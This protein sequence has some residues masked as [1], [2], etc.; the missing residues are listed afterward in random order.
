M[1]SRTLENR[2]HTEGTSFQQLLTEVRQ[3]KAVDFL[4]SSDM[5]ID[6][7]GR[8]VGFSEPTNFTRAFKDWTGV[9]P[10]HYRKQLL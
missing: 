1:T 6:D 4:S 3:T 10:T 7:I 8:A 5:S 9:P 2:L